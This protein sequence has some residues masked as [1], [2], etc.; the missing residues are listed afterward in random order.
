MTTEKHSKDDLHIFDM[1]DIHDVPEEVA[2]NL[3]GYG[4]RLL[5]KKIYSLF[6]IKDTLSMDE[7]LLALYR[8]YG[9]K[10]SRSS[11]YQKLKTEI[12]AG[13]MTRGSG[14]YLA[15]RLGYQGVENE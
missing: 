5:L 6:Q 11:A 8:K 12:E 9:V 1:T 2:K 14:Y 10:L 15:Y 4:N 13:R 3:I 7:I